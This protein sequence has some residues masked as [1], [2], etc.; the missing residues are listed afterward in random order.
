MA[1]TEKHNLNYLIKHNK[2]NRFYLS[3][4]ICV[5]MLTSVNLTG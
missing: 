1:Q 4:T 3:L 2:K 5:A